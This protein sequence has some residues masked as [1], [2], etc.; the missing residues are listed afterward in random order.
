MQDLE[1]LPLKEQD[2][3]VTELALTADPTEET[4]AEREQAAARAAATAAD[5]VNGP[6]P[7]RTPDLPAAKAAGLAVTTAAAP[8]AD[9]LPKQ[10][11]RSKLRI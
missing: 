3:A 11:D 4:V 8:A 6:A 5:R 10:A 2:P 9:L 7:G 1:V